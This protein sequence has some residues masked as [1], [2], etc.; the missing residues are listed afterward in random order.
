MKILTMNLINMKLLHKNHRLKRLEQPKKLI[1]D[2]NL[3]IIL[4]EISILTLIK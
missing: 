3:M 1:K 4:P 2:F